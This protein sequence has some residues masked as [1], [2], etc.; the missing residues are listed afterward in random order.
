MNPMQSFI[1]VSLSS[2]LLV[3][4]ALPGSQEASAHTALGASKKLTQ[5]EILA[6]VTRRQTTFYRGSGRR[7]I[8]AS[9]VLS[10]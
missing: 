7:A 9:A 10:R 3:G 6:K 4:L 2:L 8:L 5:S 1:S